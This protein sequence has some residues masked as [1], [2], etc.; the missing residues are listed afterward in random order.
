M[1]VINHRFHISINLHPRWNLGLLRSGI[2]RCS[3]S[4]G[5][6]EKLHLLS[7]HWG[8]LRQTR[9]MAWLMMSSLQCP[10]RKKNHLF[11]GKSGMRWSKACFKISVCL[12]STGRDASTSVFL[13]VTVHSHQSGGLINLLFL[14]M[15]KHFSCEH[16]IALQFIF[17]FSVCYLH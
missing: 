7:S 13:F 17:F 14:K 8:A 3:E 5:Y 1:L 4:S 9:G 10:G 12:Y 16:K 2:L 15:P 11:W 6:Q